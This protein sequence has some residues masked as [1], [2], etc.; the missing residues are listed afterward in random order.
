MILLDQRTIGRTAPVCF[1]DDQDRVVIRPKPG[2]WLLEP[3]PDVRE[4]CPA[5][6]G[7]SWA[8]GTPPDD[9]RGSSWT[10]ETGTVPA[11]VVLCAT[12]GHEEALPTMYAF[13]PGEAAESFEDDADPADYLDPGPLGLYLS[14]AQ[15][16]LWPPSASP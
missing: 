13:D 15:L 1:L 11:Q 6:G 7:T 2:D 5:C 10:A 9:A 3:L 16:A 12:C 8:L 14:E 4:E